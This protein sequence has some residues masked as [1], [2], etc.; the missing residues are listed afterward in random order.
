MSNSHTTTWIIRTDLPHKYA[1]S[2]D[3]LD[4]FLKKHGADGANSYIAFNEIG[5]K[6]AKKEHQ[7]I[8]LTTVTNKKDTI[9]HQL[10]AAFPEL[11]A[12][13]KGSGGATLYTITQYNPTDDWGYEGF[14]L[15]Y[16]CKD[17][18][19]RCGELWNTDSWI[20]HREKRKNYIK[21]NCYEPVEC[22]ACGRKKPKKVSQDEKL[23]DHLNKLFNDKVELYPETYERTLAMEIYK[24]Y[25]KY[26]KAANRNWVKVA[27]EQ[28]LFYA[29][30][31]APTEQTRNEATAEALKAIIAT[32]NELVYK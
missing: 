14:R 12:A 13:R 23:R 17:G 20:K 21:E 24:Y 7:H 15:H 10:T 1:G 16:V 8:I 2:T 5:K 32:K 25:K 31:F 27:A 9:R 11:K 22:K 29:P 28:L 4:N 3:P 30:V 26:G 18:N 6:G 19:H